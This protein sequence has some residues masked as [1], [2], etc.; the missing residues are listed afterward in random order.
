LSSPRN[1]SEILDFG[2]FDHAV[3]EI[4]H[5]GHRA[6]ENP[7][8]LQDQNNWGPD[9]CQCKPDTPAESDPRIWL[10]EDHARAVWTIGRHRDPGA[11]VSLANTAWS[12]QYLDS[13]YILW[14]VVGNVGRDPTLFQPRRARN[15]AY[16]VEC[17]DE[18]RFS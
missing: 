17:D 12:E 18:F 5:L 1:E 11:A 4:R 16:A 10:K 9:E 15:A 3:D 2:A 14:V 8:V 13:S 6:A 7:I